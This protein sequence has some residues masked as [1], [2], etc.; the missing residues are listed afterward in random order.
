MEQIVGLSKGNGRPDKLIQAAVALQQIPVQPGYF[1][2]LA[3][4]IV[5][6]PLALSQ[7]IAG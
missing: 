7:F 4:G 6:S 2:V 5:I 3:V 1:I